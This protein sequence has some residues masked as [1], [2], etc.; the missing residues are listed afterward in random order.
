MKKNNDLSRV[1]N[2]I[3]RLIF[4]SFGMTLN[5]WAEGDDILGGETPVS[6]LE[7]KNNS[8]ESS[9]PE[10]SEGMGQIADL[11]GQVPS[12]LGVPNGLLGDFGHY[13]LSLGAFSITPM[14]CLGLALG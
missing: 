9:T 14:T 2:W 6:E 13:S 1:S 7:N 5:V 4:V 3:L 12:G 11:D 8:Q 10:V